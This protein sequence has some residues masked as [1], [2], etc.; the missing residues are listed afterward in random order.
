MNNHNATK[1]IVTI[2]LVNTHLTN[3]FQCLCALVKHQFDSEKLE[4]THTLSI[5]KENE[6]IWIK[7]K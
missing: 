2:N 7:K 5:D 1:S 4:E 6:I 3:A